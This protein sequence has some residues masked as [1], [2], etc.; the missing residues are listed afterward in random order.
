MWR[1]FIIL[2]V[3]IVSSCVKIP[4]LTQPEPFSDEFLISV[5]PGETT[6]EQLL[7]T[8]GKPQVSRRGEN[9]WVY[10]KGRGDFEVL[11]MPV[12][13]PPAA[14][15]IIPVPIG[16]EY[17]NPDSM[18]IEFIDDQLTNVELLDNRHGCTVSGICLLS[19]WYSVFRPFDTR[20]PLQ[21]WPVTATVTSKQTDDLEAKKFSNPPLGCS[22]YSYISNSA[23]SGYPVL[24][25]INNEQLIPVAPSSYL[26]ALLPAGA[27]TITV[28]D[29]GTKFIKEG[30]AAFLTAADL[31]CKDG[32]VIF[33]Q[34][35]FKIDRNKRS[36]NVSF[37]GD[38]T[39]KSAVLERSLI[40]S[41]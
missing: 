7:D 31:E 13:I 25:G 36:A 18:I 41:K 30:E 15:G 27:N 2:W 16:L 20:P 33:L 3:A 22:L 28:Y 10:A 23:W 24:L 17:N 21:F 37:D 4:D 29:S 32:N 39:G 19:G 26:Y 35:D 8:L 12:V 34:V 1:T 40:I 9:I 6:R 5:I 38:E 11:L 14:V